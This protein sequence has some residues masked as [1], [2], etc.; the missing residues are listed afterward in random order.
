MVL[1]FQSRG[2]RHDGTTFLNMADFHEEFQHANLQR[3]KRKDCKISSLSS[4]NLCAKTLG[5]GYSDKQEKGHFCPHGG[6]SLVEKEKSIN[7]NM[8]VVLRLGRHRGPWENLQEHLSQRVGCESRKT[9]CRAG[10]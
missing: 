9:S 6:F 8:A 5:S 7:S 2:H 3:F 10:I 4:T 1:N